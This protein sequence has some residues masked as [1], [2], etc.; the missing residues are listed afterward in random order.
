MRYADLQASLSGFDLTEMDV[1]T[2]VLILGGKENAL[3]LVRRF[4]A[5]GI[6]TRVSGPADCW[7]M[8]SHYCREKF[9][10]PRGISSAQYW[11]DLLLSG[12]DAGLHAGLHAELHGSLLIACSDEAIDFLA[13]NRTELESLY[14]FDH[15]DPDMQLSL[16]D[17]RDTLKLAQSAGVAT[18]QY[19]TVN[20]EEDLAALRQ[21]VEFPVMVKP[22]ISH[23]FIS[24][25]G[26]K[27]FIIDSEF[28]ELAEK[29]R[30]AWANN[31]EV[32]VIEMI[33]GPD[34]QLSS[35]YTYIGA[36]HQP[37]FD[38][39]KSVI[40]RFPVN[41]GLGCYHKSEWLPETAEAGSKFFQGIG[42]TG[43]GNIEF[44]RDPRDQILKVIESNARFTSAQE[45]IIRAGAPIDFIYYCKATGQKAP[46][47]ETYDQD[48]TLWY[49]LRDFLAFVEMRRAGS[50]S[51]GQWLRSL[52]P[53]KHVSPLHNMSDPF[54]SL[55]ALTTRIE[56][57]VTGLL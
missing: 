13:R 51:T 38:Y 47:F 21:S 1:S 27:L 55:A 9:P 45:L 23:E 33:P 8:H 5:A 35:Y 16:L 20:N 37:S 26:L 3:S 34:S 28:D 50:I 29:V 56:K 54:P 57:T 30:L 49:G 6:A 25:F 40:R 17:K 46:G 15:G 42:F 39:T 48:L 43:F 10:V 36:D 41:R 18:P 2:P 53:F 24:I 52:F 7:G 32:M 14:Q 31:V 11:H 22:I 44:K 12:K 19:W 4:G